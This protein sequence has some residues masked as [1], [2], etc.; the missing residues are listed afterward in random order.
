MFNSYYYITDDVDI[1]F[2]ICLLLIP[3]QTAL[4]SPWITMPGSRMRGPVLMKTVFRSTLTL[5]PDGLIKHATT[6]PRTLY[7]NVCTC[8]QHPRNVC[9]N[10]CIQPPRTLY[11]NVCIQPPR[12]LYV[13]VCVTDFQA[14]RHKEQLWIT[15]KS[16]IQ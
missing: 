15:V 4:R 1:Y 13:N 5:T 12:T 10:V 2:E 6:P 9:V 16:F 11:A 7:V 14:G 8:I 3:W